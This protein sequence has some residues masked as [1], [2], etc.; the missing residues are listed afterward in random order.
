[1]LK[2]TSAITPKSQHNNF[3]YM[4]VK[5]SMIIL[6]K[7]LRY[8]GEYPFTLYLAKIINIC[9]IAKCC[10]F[11]LSAR[12]L[13]FEIAFNL[14][15]VFATID[16]LDESDESVVKVSLMKTMKPKENIL[17]MKILIMMSLTN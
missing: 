13:K 12:E 17:K 16:L 5:N 10:R 8:G 1:M 3:D 11:D 2:S 15:G 4:A 14:H 6:S 7:S 9:K